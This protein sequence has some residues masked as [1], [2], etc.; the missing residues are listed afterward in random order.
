ME[1]SAAGLPSGVYFYKL[2][3]ENYT[4]VKKMILMK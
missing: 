4:Q 3:A 2:D 1:F